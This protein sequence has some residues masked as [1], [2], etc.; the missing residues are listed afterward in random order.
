VDI[1]VLREKKVGREK[2]FINPRM[3]KLLTAGDYRVPGFTGS[4]NKA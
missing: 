1:D 4:R 2:L 3:M